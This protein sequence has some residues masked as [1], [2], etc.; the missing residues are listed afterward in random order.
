MGLVKLKSKETLVKNLPSLYREL[1]SPF[2]FDAPLE[3]EADI[4]YEDLEESTY[5]YIYLFTSRSYEV[6]IRGNYWEIYV[7][8]EQRIY[9]NYMFG[10]VPEEI[11][12]KVEELKKKH[13]VSTD[14][15]WTTYDID[16]IIDELADYI[17]TLEGYDI[18]YIEK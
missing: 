9:D 6:S 10:T 18:I 14:K 1:C 4:N 13:T 8:D 5:N 2:I 7:Q 3:Y 12:N 11:K 15:N 16:S 17:F